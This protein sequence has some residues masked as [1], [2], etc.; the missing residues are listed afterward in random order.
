[1]T[2]IYFAEPQWLHLLWL[3][4]VFVALLLFL[5][6]R[7][8]HLLSRF[9]SK[10][11]QPRLVHNTGRSRRIL[12][13]ILLGLTGVFLTLALMRP[14][15][16]LSFI[17]TPRVGAEIMVCLD[18]S[19]SMLAEDV[20]PNRL[21]RAKAELRDL[22]SYLD[23]DQV[24]LIAFAG[25]ATVL[26]PLTPDFGFLRLVLDEA[27]PHSVARGGTRLEEP[28][29]KAVAG[30]ANS[31][32][33]ARSILL[34]TDGEDHDS[35]P[36]EA[37]KAAA[38]RGI[39]ILAIGFGSESGSEIRI[40]DPATGARTVLRDGDGNIVSSRL[41][42]DLLREMVL[43]TEG[44]YIP[45]G[46]G[47]LDL[48]SIYQRHIAG[49]TRSTLDG[50]SRTVRND[51]YQWAIL[52]ALLS[53][54]AAVA[55]TAG[56]RNEQPVLSS[57]AGAGL[58]L[59]ILLSGLLGTPAKSI[60]QDQNA[61]A[62]N[63]ATTEEQG[64]AVFA[65]IPDEIL[66]DSRALYNLALSKL[67]QQ[68]L[69]RA[70]QLLTTTRDKA[71][72]DAEARLRAT[73]NLGWLEV[74]RADS[75]LQ[76]QPEEALQALHKAA[77][78]F[79]EAIDLRPKH[80]DSRYN[81]EIVLRRALALADSL[82]KRDQHDVLSLLNALLEQQRAYLNE[83][84]NGVDLL[85]ARADP[86]A[87]Q[88]A[89]PA[90][91]QLS[92][93]QL[94]LLD[95][96][97]TVSERAEQE[98][99]VINAKEEQERS[100]EE[101]VQAAQLTQMLAYL[102]RAR[103]RMGQTR[104]QLRRLQAERGYRRA[105]A[106]LAALKRAR[107]Q[108]QDPVARLDGLLTD[109]LEIARFSSVKALSEQS[110]QHAEQAVLP[111]WLSNEYLSESQLSLSER[112]AELES[113]LAAGLAQAAE[114]T[115]TP[116]DEQQR[117]FINQ[118]QVAQPLIAEAL[119]S[120][121]TA[122][123]ALQ[124]TR[125]QEALQPQQIGLSK[126][127]QAREQFLDLRRLLELVYQQEQQI[128]GFMTEPEAG[129]EEVETKE[130]VD[131]TEY[132]PLAG[133]L[134][135]KNKKRAARVGTMIADQIS[136]ALT[137]EEQAQ[138]AVAQSQ[139]SQQGQNQNPSQ[140][141][142]DPQVKANLQQAQAELQRLTQADELQLKMQQSMHAADEIL[143]NAVAA[144]E[145][146]QPAALVQVRDA[147]AKALADIEA[148]R[149]LFFSLID[150]LK[151]TASKQ[152][153]L[154][155]ETEAITALADE[156][157]VSATQTQ[158][159]PLQPRQQ[160]LADFTEQLLTALR[161]QAEQT[162]PQALAPDQDQQAAQAEDMQARMRQAAEHVA[163]AQAH[164]QQAAT[165]MSNQ[166]EELPKVL[167][168]VREQQDTAVTELQQALALLQPPQENQNQNQ[169]QNQQQQQSEQ[170]QQNQ[171]QQA[172]Q[173]QQEIDPRQ[174][175]QGIRDREAERRRQQQQRNQKQGYEPVAKDW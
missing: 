47:L 64:N 151:E 30:F 137:A 21:Q 42:G 15:W 83:L 141:P 73:Y 109:G 33:A 25:R 138:Q 131:V 130:Q 36:L 23:G 11:L 34:I 54:L 39:R 2:E 133:E 85:A 161:E 171:Q 26:S 14:Q 53:L 111:T 65:D 59:L 76:E 146:Q 5:E 166:Q 71:G 103:E 114:Q 172:E 99:Q 150:H 164:M 122:T 120:F 149:R 80:E 86:N 121:E 117:Q 66:N 165:G 70:E 134:H 174:L 96:A 45:A 104:S 125:L 69:A 68:D 29:R 22:L 13:I 55:S 35:F 81:L 142:P 108:L 167:T 148:L 175:L 105:A 93:S 116:T 156:E 132:L 8:N 82:A 46:T 57:L 136:Q 98:L 140:A 37:A 74:Q 32:D 16:G 89:R 94:A 10:T 139:L 127:R 158:L 58:I 52:L 88:Q 87:A 110:L 107:E 101:Q 63:V 119:A 79:R 128:N 173:Q 106:A 7:G 126:L 77:D 147:V 160:A 67:Q 78:W 92:L 168:A 75:L 154:A 162:A 40:T 56:K 44:A 4:L 50:Q 31:G 135:T 38:E 129:A 145:E 144:T 95:E 18:V 124:E 27:G 163:T 157:N 61:E 123:T 12:R 72:A 153:D 152:I 3:V 20:A 115:E 49:L 113:G 169:D 62:N 170:Q 118:L 143:S 43:L 28:I 41:D 91:R 100:P 60:A 102:H 6:R 9:V 155:D 97:Q 24:G 112:L 90:F 159:G 19:R 84:R 17:S 1:M 51:A 48:E